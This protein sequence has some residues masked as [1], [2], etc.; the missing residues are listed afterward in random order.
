MSACQKA[1]DEQIQ[2][3]AKTGTARNAEV[4]KLHR[5]TDGEDTQDSWRLPLSSKVVVP[6][7]GNDQFSLFSIAGCAIHCGSKLISGIA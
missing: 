1:Q 7:P 4:P 5:S 3:Y 6:N 2:C